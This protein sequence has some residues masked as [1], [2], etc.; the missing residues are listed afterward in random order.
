MLKMSCFSPM[1]FAL[2]LSFTVPVLM[3]LGLVSDD[4]SEIKEY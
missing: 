4:N 1:V 2:N 3:G